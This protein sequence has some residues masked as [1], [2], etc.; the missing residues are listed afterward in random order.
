VNSAGH[1]SN[2]SSTGHAGDGHDPVLSR[3]LENPP[4]VPAAVA[5]HVFTVPASEQDRLP[6]TVSPPAVPMPSTPFSNGTLVPADAVE[7]SQFS[8]TYNPVPVLDEE[9]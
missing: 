1:L 6:W 3:L 8:D 5:S 2:A 9:E 4:N 7:Y